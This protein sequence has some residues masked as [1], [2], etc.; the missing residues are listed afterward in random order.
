VAVVLPAAWLARDQ[1]VV[2]R[3]AAALRDDL[4]ALARAL[5]VH[6]PVI[7]VVP[8]M[9]SLEGFDVYRERIAPKY[10]LRQRCGFSFPTAEPYARERVAS[11]IRFMT[12]GVY[13]RVLEAMTERAADEV[14]NARLFQFYRAI[15]GLGPGLEAALAS[16][17]TTAR[18]GDP[19]RLQGCYLAGTGRNR[20]RPAFVDRLVRSTKGGL[21]S[22]LLAPLWSDQARADD[23]TYYRL[24]AGVGVVGAALTALVWR[25]LLGLPG[26]SR[27]WTVVPIGIAVLWTAVLVSLRLRAG[28]SPVRGARDA[29]P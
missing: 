15:L 20:T 17:L 21:F 23:R 6:C 12:Q 29:A 1:D 5:K 16:A 3:A 9:E 2:G 4:Q 22:D 8:G 19:V 18:R 11:G 13:E 14:A 25:Y 27:W 26:L 7:V 10:D 24:A 28:A